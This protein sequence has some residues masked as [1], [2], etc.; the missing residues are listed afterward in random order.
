[1]I[2]TRALSLKPQD[3]P[4]VYKNIY[5]LLES[6]EFPMHVDNVDLTTSANYILNY[7]DKITR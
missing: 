3:F 1:M 6:Q 2:V 5:M 7:Y 4:V